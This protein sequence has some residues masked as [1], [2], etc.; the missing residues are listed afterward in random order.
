MELIL[1]THI[2]RR[3]T[4]DVPFFYTPSHFSELKVLSQLFQPIYL[5]FSYLNSVRHFSGIE[6]CR[7]YLLL[8]FYYGSR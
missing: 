5:A 4:Q 1:K 3:P 7:E 6:F 2:E 8:L